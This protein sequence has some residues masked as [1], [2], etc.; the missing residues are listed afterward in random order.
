MAVKKPAQ[1]K[2]RKVSEKKLQ[3]VKLLEQLGR[4]T[5]QLTEEQEYS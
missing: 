2:Q 5:S 1:K 4:L 3:T